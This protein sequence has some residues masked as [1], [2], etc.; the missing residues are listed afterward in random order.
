MC[1]GSSQIDVLVV[2]EFHGASGLKLLLMLVILNG[3]T[4]LIPASFALFLDSTL[5][6]RSNCCLSDK[7]MATF[8]THNGRSWSRPMPSNWNLFWSCPAM[9]V[10]SLLGRACYGRVNSIKVEFVIFS[11]TWIL[12]FITSMCLDRLRSRVSTTEIERE[13]DLIR[14]FIR[15]NFVK[16]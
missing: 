9:Y 11:I 7:T 1:V 13:K 16:N 15:K 10:A 6:E 5:R 2:G 4:K 3:A 12:I 14:S 8:P